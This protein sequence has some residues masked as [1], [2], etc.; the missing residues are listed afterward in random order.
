MPFDGLKEPHGLA[1][2]TAGNVY[3][4]DSRNNRVLKL[5]PR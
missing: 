3:V 1:V 4:S 2:G 5:P